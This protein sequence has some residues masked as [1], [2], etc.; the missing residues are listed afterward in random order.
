M[1]KII[2]V[3]L[4]I[5]V[6]FSV[7]QTVSFAKTGNLLENGDFEDPNSVPCETYGPSNLLLVRSEYAETGSAGL[8]CYERMGKYSTVKFNILQLMAKSGPGAYTFSMSIRLN[9]KSDKAHKAQLVVNIGGADGKDSYIVS[10]PQTE[11]K[12]KWQV[13]TVTRTLTEAQLYESTHM[14][15]YP[16]VEGTVNADFC[17][18]NVSIVKEGE[19]NGHKREDITE[20]KRHD[21]SEELIIN[22]D[23]ETDFLQNPLGDEDDEDFEN[24]FSVYGPANKIE[25]SS[26]FAHRG[27]NGV[28]VSNR[29]GKFSTVKYD[30]TDTIIDAGTGSYRASMWL[31]LASPGQESASGNKTMLVIKYTTSAGGSY[32]HTDAVELTGEWT[33]FVLEFK[34]NFSGLTSFWIYPQVE[35]D[36]PYIDFCV[37]DFS[38]VK[39]GEVGEDEIEVEGGGTKAEIDKDL[40]TVDV[41]DTAKKITTTVEEREKVTTV[42]AIRWD[43]WYGEAGSVGKQVA[44]T[45]SP[46]KYHFRAPFFAT[47]NDDNTISYP[48]EYTQELFDKEMEYAIDAGIDYFAYNWYTDGMQKARQLH[49]TSK[50]KNDV[51]LCVILG[52]ASSDYTKSEMAKLLKDECYMTVLGGRPLMYYFA[53]AKDT[54]EDIKYYQAL[55][56]KL[57]IPE[58]YAVVMNLS[59]TSTIGTGA[60]AIGQYAINGKGGESF[61]SLTEHALSLRTSFGVSGLPFV[62][63]VTTGWNSVTRFETPV[64]WITT[65]EDSWAEYATPDEIYEH[66][67]ETLDYMQTPAA[68]SKTIPNTVLMYAW[69]EHDEGGWICPTIAVDENGNQLFNEDGSKKIDTSRI[70]AVKKAISEYKATVSDGKTDSEKNNTVLL[71]V[72]ICAGI[73]IV[74]GGATAVILILRRK[75]KDGTEN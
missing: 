11:L 60:D 14:W 50:Y 34:H 69:N 74:A 17:I 54:A 29:E 13:L 21:A 58:P 30:A 22:G 72:L 9:E 52:G 31:K 68:K 75:K 10:Q 44:A 53:T 35:S 70:E 37:D 62:P 47:V 43:A 28:R 18:D 48:K 45:L 15:L 38:L 61:K 71:P 2:S 16:Q 59:S 67:K 66:L 36:K 23:F 1:K 42:G 51:K 57:G 73:V 12:D 40:I 25:I 24:L 27:E 55:C 8:L 39:Y 46:A 19:I 63:T 20:V 56:R 41:P 7:I 26:E 33:K 64:S 65:T 6:I 3:L 32:L 4:S 49:V 5:M